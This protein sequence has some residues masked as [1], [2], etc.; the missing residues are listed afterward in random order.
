MSLS[1][2]VLGAQL[3][4]T[5]IVHYWSHTQ[6]DSCGAL[7]L[8][9]VPTVDMSSHIEYVVLTTLL[10]PL[11][12]MSEHIDKLGLTTLLPAPVAMSSHID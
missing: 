4:I 6:L 5:G 10:S 12:D 7:N 9:S 11:V 8:I 1:T 2:S 3:A